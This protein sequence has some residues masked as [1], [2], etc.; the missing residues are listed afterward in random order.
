MNMNELIDE[1]RVADR[2]RK[3]RTLP[4]T[5]NGNAVVGFKEERVGDGKTALVLLTDADGE[6]KE[7]PAKDEDSVI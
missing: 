4:V 5:V 1:M 7:A 3:N 6:K 2:D